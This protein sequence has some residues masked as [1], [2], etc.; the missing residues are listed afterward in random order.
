MAEINT[1]DM[2]RFSASF[3]NSSGVAADPTTVT[4]K[5]VVNDVAVDYTYNPGDIVRDSLGNFHMDYTIPT[6]ENFYEIIYR[7]VGTGAVAAAQEG[8]FFAVSRV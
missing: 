4:L 8:A 5:L 6:A 3:A 2:V 7:W 1:G